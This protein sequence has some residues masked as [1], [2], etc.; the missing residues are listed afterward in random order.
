MKGLA[1]GPEP[2]FTIVIASTCIGQAYSERVLQLKK[3]LSENTNRGNSTS[4]L[5]L[6]NICIH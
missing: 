6:R 3:L 5:G 1:Q 4:L 2:S